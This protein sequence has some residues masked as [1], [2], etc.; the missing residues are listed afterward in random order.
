M[1]LSYAGVDVGFPHHTL[2]PSA[3]SL[4]RWY[5]LESMDAGIPYQSF[6]FNYFSDLIF[7]KVALYDCMIE[8]FSIL[9]YMFT[10]SI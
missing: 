3:S 1:E 5:R 10:G 9:L 8:S 7:N 4:L 2:V 6:Y